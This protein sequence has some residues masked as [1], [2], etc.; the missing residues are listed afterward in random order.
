MVCIVF[1]LRVVSNRTIERTRGIVSIVACMC[2]CMCG[3]HV[4]QIGHPTDDLDINSKRLPNLIFPV[5]L[6][7]MTCKLEHSV[8]SADE[9]DDRTALYLRGK[10]GSV[11]VAPRLQYSTSTQMPHISPLEVRLHANSDA[12]HAD[13]CLLAKF[14]PFAVCTW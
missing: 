9:R 10:D 3:H 12:D 8:A 7:E 14:V 5:Q 6:T 4:Q 11:S 13:N 1:F 2:M